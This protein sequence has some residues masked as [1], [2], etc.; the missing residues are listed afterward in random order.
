MKK[1]VV[2][3]LAAV[4]LVSVFSLAGCG[5]NNNAT[6]NKPADNAAALP[7]QVQKIKDAGVLR[8]GVKQDVPGFGLLDPKTNKFEGMEIDLA[9]KI[10]KEIFGSSYSDDKVK[11][12]PVTADTRG[13]LLD[14][15]QIDMV[16]ATFTIKPDRQEKWNFS[17]PY[18]T[19]SVG[20]MVKKDSGFKSLKDLA[21]KTIAVAT[22]S[23]S[24]ASVEAE[25]KVQGVTGIKFQ[26]FANYPACAQALASGRVDGFSV[27]RSILAGYLNDS[28]VIL[29]DSFAP[30]DYGIATKKTNTELATWVNDLI[31]TWKSDGTIDTIAAKYN[32][33]K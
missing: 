33:N 22:G 5:S 31:S 14:N 11:F 30:Q 10:G 12:T 9:H 29:P 26:Q 17:D 24:Q 16:I 8:V 3:G 20:V 13:T 2:L 23:T 25:A 19:D 1:L 15:G 27:D 6:D 7:A 4:L 21:G 18:Y 32:L 28:V